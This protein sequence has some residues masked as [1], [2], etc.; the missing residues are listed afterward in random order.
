MN[1]DLDLTELLLFAVF[2]FEVL[3][4]HLG[5]TEEGTV[6]LIGPGVEL[7]LGTFTDL[8][9]WHISIS[10][11][12]WDV[13]L[14]KFTESTALSGAWWHWVYIDLLVVLGPLATLEALPLTVLILE[15]V[16][17]MMPVSLIPRPIVLKSFFGW[18]PVVILT[19]PEFVPDTL[20]WVPLE[21]VSWLP[22]LM[23]PVANLWM[24]RVGRYEVK[25]CLLCVEDLFVFGIDF[26]SI[27]TEVS[28][29]VLFDVVNMSTNTMVVISKLD[30]VSGIDLSKLINIAHSRHVVALVLGGSALDKVHDWDRVGG[31]NQG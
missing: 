10:Q 22:A 23:T 31:A 6:G 9:S 25:A 21:W 8:A 14:L 5:S 20:S 17:A 24:F 28:N 26:L 4:E 18:A 2:T 15:N 16:A 1:A 27:F 13:D 12:I 7:L 11:L 29:M 30:E 19:T 3:L